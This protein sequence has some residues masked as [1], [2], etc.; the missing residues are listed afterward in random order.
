MFFFRLFVYHQTNIF[1]QET[2]KFTNQF[3]S[4]SFIFCIIAEM[5]ISFFGIV[6]YTTT[7][8]LY[9]DSRFFFLQSIHLLQKK[10]MQGKTKK[11]REIQ[12]CVCV[13]CMPVS[14]TKWRWWWWWWFFLFFQESLF[15]GP[16]YRKKISCMC[17]FSI[18]NR[19]RPL[20]RILC[21]CV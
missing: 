13:C 15:S 19:H 3:V 21:I 9:N 7:T 11:K 8:T 10:I 20:K 17:V 14:G 1:N 4:A 18:S 6:D 2:L 12:F 5:D 16:F